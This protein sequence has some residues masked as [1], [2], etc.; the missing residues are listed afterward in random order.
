[1]NAQELYEQLKNAADFFGVGFRG[2]DQVKVE[3]KLGKIIL[4]HERTSITIDVMTSQDLPQIPGL[5]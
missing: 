3:V 5:S 2:F 1:M 4:S